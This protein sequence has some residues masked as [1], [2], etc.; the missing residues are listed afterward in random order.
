MLIQI[1]IQLIF[2]WLYLVT[3]KNET[4]NHIRYFSQCFHGSLLSDPDFSLQ[5]QIPT[6]VKAVFTQS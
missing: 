1:H 3:I 4:E 2:S 5:K 6:K